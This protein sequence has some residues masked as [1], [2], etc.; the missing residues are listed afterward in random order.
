[1][2]KMS[3]KKALIGAIVVMV[4]WF[5]VCFFAIRYISNTREAASYNNFKGGAET[6]MQTD[7]AFIQQYGKISTSI[8]ESNQLAANEAATIREAYLDFTCTSDAGVEFRV[9]IFGHTDSE[10]N[11]IVYRYE[12]LPAK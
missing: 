8:P 6:F 9:R 5:A 1:M 4:V 10:T 12:A 2:A 11:K 7:E 3:K